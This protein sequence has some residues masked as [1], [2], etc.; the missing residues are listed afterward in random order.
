MIH[1][2]KG[3]LI[4][5]LKFWFGEEYSQIFDNDNFIVE[6]DKDTLYVYVYTKVEE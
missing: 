5:K 1:Y 2:K 4:A 3:E 6:I